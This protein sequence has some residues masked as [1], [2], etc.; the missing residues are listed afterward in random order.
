MGVLAGIVIFAGK[1]QIRVER[2]QLADGEIVG[3]IAFAYA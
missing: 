2:L 3:Q 1:L